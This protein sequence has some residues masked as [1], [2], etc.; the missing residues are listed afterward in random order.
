MTTIARLRA[1]ITGWATWADGNED[2]QLI[3]RERGLPRWPTPA[4]FARFQFGRDDE[5]AQVI[6]HDLD[7]L[8]V[9]FTLPRL[10]LVEA[11]EAELPAIL[12]SVPLRQQLTQT[13]LLPQ[14]Y[15]RIHLEY[16]Q[17]RSEL[18]KTARD[19][20]S[21]SGAQLLALGM[22]WL[23]ALRLVAA[24]ERL[25]ANLK[26]RIGRRDWRLVDFDFVVETS[27]RARIQLATTSGTLGALTLDDL[28]PVLRLVWRTVF[29]AG[30]PNCATFLE[31]WQ[32]LWEHFAS[33]LVTTSARP[34]ITENDETS[35][36]G[37][38][39]MAELR[40]ELLHDV[41]DTVELP[42]DPLAL[43]DDGRLP[44]P[45]PWVSRGLDFPLARLLEYECIYY[46]ISTAVQLLVGYEKAHRAS[47]AAFPGGIKVVERAAQQCFVERRQATAAATTLLHQIVLQHR[48]TNLNDALHQIVLGRMH[49]F[50]LYAGEPEF[51]TIR[52]IYAQSVAAGGA[53]AGSVA[54]ANIDAIHDKP[55]SG[56]VLSALRADDYAFVSHLFE[57]KALFQRIIAE[58]WLDGGQT[59]AD[60]GAPKLERLAN[61]LLLE[62]V[63]KV[64]A[65]KGCPE[66][67]RIR[68]N[69][70][71]D[72]L[73][74]HQV[75]PRLAESVPRLDVQRPAGCL[76]VHV[77]R[78][79]FLVV[80]PNTVFEVGSFPAAVATWLALARFD[81][82]DDPR[83]R[84]ISEREPLR[85]IPGPFVPLVEAFRASV[86][87]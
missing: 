29:E 45:L 38:D 32:A 85:F 57:D 72:Y 7:G 36:A 54:H 21:H 1:L 68:H 51:Y 52:Q 34:V 17:I 78:R 28:G 25:Q 83:E 13:N 33:V 42:D 35:A 77:L 22:H 16:L 26:S 3:G 31:Y 18:F 71:V 70:F 6:D 50:F 2:V 64:M 49:D 23:C 62:L 75:Y 82:V 80:A 58:V 41:V 74:F 43:M 61:V 27:E 59:V 39:L 24:H 73:A 30:L 63:E 8:L 67:H 47:L 84:H 19:R 55:F 86:S 10:E 14:A 81:T 48:D 66:S 65:A 9:E 44:M 60:G 40:S 12:A 76:L 15:R 79:N 46:H 11:I 87:S 5:I 69:A 53:M 56:H 4:A 20:A 37:E